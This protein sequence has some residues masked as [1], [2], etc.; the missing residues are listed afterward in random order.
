MP[1]MVE[2]PAASI[3]ALG[4]LR[5]V[6][7]LISNGSISLV[8]SGGQTGRSPCVVEFLWEDAFPDDHVAHLPSGLQ[9]HQASGPKCDVWEPGAGC[10]IYMVICISHTVPTGGIEPES[11]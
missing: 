3:L 6:A 8:S 11:Q 5:N 4:R 1:T 2:L 10:R 7:S 9:C